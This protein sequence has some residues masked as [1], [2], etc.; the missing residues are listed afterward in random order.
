MTVQRSHERG[1]LRSN[2]RDVDVTGSLATGR[3][4]YTAT[5][6]PYGKVLVAGGQDIIDI[7]RER[8]TL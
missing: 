3:I 7:L 5:L 8:G 2:E 6:L 1:T 4:F